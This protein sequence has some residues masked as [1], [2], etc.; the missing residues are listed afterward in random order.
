MQINFNLQSIKSEIKVEQIENKVFND[1]S[2]S[3]D[4]VNDYEEN[5]RKVDNDMDSKTKKPKQ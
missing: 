1:E 4:S 3:S 2:F 5:C